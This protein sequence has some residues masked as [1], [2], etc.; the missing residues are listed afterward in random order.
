MNSQ[1]LIITPDVVKGFIGVQN[2][3]PLTL[4]SRA[5]PAKLR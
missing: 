5:V 2:L 3:D 4:Q 1:P